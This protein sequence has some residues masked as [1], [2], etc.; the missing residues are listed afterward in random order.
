[1]SKI[2]VL[3]GSPRR[4]GNTEKLVE[5]FVKGAQSAGHQVTNFSIIDTKVNGCIA[6]DYCMNNEGKCVQKDGM[7][8]IYEQLHQAD[9]VVFASPSYYFGW[10]AQLK[11]IVDRFYAAGAKPFP[12][13][14]AA[15]LVALGGHAETD[16]AAAL[17]S[18]KSI[19][20]FLQWQDK[21]V[22]IADNVMAKDDI[23]GNPALQKAEEL[24][25][26]I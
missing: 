12:I 21:G 13:T 22:V 15:M 7:Q 4:N 24:G 17:V 19:I 6:C 5:A 18:Y 25:R 1:M 10:S 26:D 2:V 11:A 3:V 20:D 16:A 9:T 14:S 8:A 23:I